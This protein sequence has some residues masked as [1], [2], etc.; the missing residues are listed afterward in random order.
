MSSRFS[1]VNVAFDSDSNPS[2]TGTAFTSART[3]AVRITHAGEKRFP[4]IPTAVRCP[5]DSPSMRKLP[6]LRHGRKVCCRFIGVVEHASSLHCHLISGAIASSVSHPLSPG[7]T[8]SS[9][10]SGLMVAASMR[11]SRST[12]PGVFVPFWR[13]AVWVK[14]AQVKRAHPVPLPE[15][16][17]FIIKRPRTDDA[18][19]VEEIRCPFQLRR[20]IFILR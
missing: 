18:R 2:P 14:P 8:T 1:A 3:A 9:S 4:T 17:C 5:M 6:Q 20:R 13:H 12:R 19:E 16:E 15:P 11:R 7:Y 10:F